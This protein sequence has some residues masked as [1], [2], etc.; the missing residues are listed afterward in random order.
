MR[1]IIKELEDKGIDLSEYAAGSHEYNIC[2]LEGEDLTLGRY[3]G[4]QKTR[5]CR[6]AGGYP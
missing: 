5:S 4:K 3:S 2:E 6:Q 1:N